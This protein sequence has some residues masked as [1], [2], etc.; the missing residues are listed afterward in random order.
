V[1]AVYVEDENPEYGPHSGRK[2]AH[3]LGSC[4]CFL[5]VASLWLV[6]MVTIDLAWVAVVLRRIVVAFL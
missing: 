2:L 4:L 6:D 5:A 3:R 1:Y